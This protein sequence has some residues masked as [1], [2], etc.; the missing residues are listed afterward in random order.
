MYIRRTLENAVPKVNNFFPV[1]LIAGPRQVGKTSLL[2][3]KTSDARTFVS[4]DALDVRS[5]A[6]KDSR[7]FLE[8]Y[9]PPVFIDE[10]QYA[11]ELFPYI[12]E[13]VDSRKEKGLFW[14]TGSQQY[15]L[16]QNITESL[17]GRVGILHLQGFSQSEKYGNADSP[18]FLPAKEYSN[19]GAVPAFDL[20]QI[21]RLIWKGSFPALWTS[22]DD[23]W[24]MFYAAYVQTYIERDVRQIINV[25]NELTFI[26]FM[27]AAAAQTGCL[28]DY[29][30]MARDTGVSEP[31]IKSW[32]SAL[33]SSGVIYLLQP[34]SGNLTKRAVKTPKLYFLDTGLACYLTR[35]N[36]PE[37]LEAGA[38]AGAIFETYVVSEILKSYWHNGKEPPVYFYRN[39][40][41]QEID[42]LIDVNG[43]LYPIEIKKKSNPDKSDVRYFRLVESELHRPCGDGAVICM[44]PTH[45]PI[46]ET[47]AAV[48]VGYI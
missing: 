25:S 1:V 46:T 7:L 35:W 33:H 5:L 4:L 6:Q 9:K 12:K 20:N 34:Y 16:M 23:Y 17:A 29:A 19:A 31:T 22:P 36:S 42:L 18:A 8:R 26:K 3:Y 13:L 10:I 44:A 30:S 11:P 2:E 15:N 43:T 48:P 41:M 21:F 38:Y 27:R 28:L 45:L 14:I 37:P 39:K 24:E 40:D 32:L 47:A